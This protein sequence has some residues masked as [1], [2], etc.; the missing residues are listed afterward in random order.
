M[1]NATVKQFK[2]ALE[3][4]KSIYPFDDEKTRLCTR[5]VFSNLHRTLSIITTD[6]RTGVV[7]EMSK[8]F[9]NEEY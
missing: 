4:M 8:L 6:E 7:I 9:S 1:E 3:K 2:D 5:D